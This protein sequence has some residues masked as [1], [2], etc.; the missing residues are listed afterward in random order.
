MARETEVLAERQF[1]F[2][3]V[4]HK[5]HLELNPCYSIQRSVTNF[6]STVQ[7]VRVTLDPDD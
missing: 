3:F 4:Y 2:H 5:S 1:Q 7:K 6:L